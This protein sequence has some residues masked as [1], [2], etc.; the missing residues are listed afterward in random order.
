MIHLRFSTHWIVTFIGPV[1]PSSLPDEG[2][3]VTA[4]GNGSNVVGVAAMDGGVVEMATG[5]KLWTGGE[6][7]SLLL[8]GIDV[9]V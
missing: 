2:D 1:G 8:I 6:V 5:V 3:S 4:L 7:G 9:G